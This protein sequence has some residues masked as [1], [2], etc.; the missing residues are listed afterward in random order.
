MCGFAAFG[1]HPKNIL[2]VMFGVLV[3]TVIMVHN[4][5]DPSVVLAALFGTALAP[6]AGQFGWKWGIVAGIIHSSV[7]LNVGGLHGWM[8]LYNNGFAAGLVCIVLVPLI[9]AIR[10]H[11]TTERRTV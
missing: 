9:E 4:L 11:N 6:I 8:N 1:K 7:V 3:S 2:P 10:N 5:Q